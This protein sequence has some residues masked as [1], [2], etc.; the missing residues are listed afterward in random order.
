MEF[1]KKLYS[2][3]TGAAVGPKL[4]DP[5]VL[6]CAVF[7]DRTNGKFYEVYFDGGQMQIQEVQQP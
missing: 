5:L 2:V 1:F 3:V 7:I 4:D 6:D